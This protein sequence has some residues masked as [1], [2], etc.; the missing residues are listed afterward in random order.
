MS[1]EERQLRRDTDKVVRKVMRLVEK[2]PAI[3]KAE[4]EA[5]NLKV[6]QYVHKA[7]GI[8]PGEISAK[9]PKVIQDMPNEYGRLEEG[10]KGWEALIAYLYLK[11]LTELGFA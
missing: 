7:T 11:Y 9:M 8:S 3:G 6:M 5:I 1:V 10:L 2:Q 4:F